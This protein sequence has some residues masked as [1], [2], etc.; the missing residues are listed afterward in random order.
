LFS[1]FENIQGQRY[2]QSDGRIFNI[3]TAVG[4]LFV[5]MYGSG[6]FA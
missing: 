6:A 1:E 5:G 2:S 3:L 4:A